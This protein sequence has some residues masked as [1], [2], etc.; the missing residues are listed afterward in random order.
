[1]DTLKKLLLI[2]RI[3]LLISGIIFLGLTLFCD[4]G[5]WTLIAAL[6]CTAL[7]N[8]MSFFPMPSKEDKK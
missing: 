7:A 4:Y 6:G 1:M 5:T 2:A 8:L 3:G